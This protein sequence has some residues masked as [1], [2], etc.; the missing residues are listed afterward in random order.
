VVAI[1]AVGELHSLQITTWLNSGNAKP[2][3]VYYIP[4]RWLPG[5]ERSLLMRT[6]GQSISIC[7]HR[8]EGVPDPRSED[9]RAHTGTT[10]RLWRHSGTL[11]QPTHI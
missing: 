9:T 10:R 1:A 6:F 7:S 2:V 5:A 3:R 8:A 11:E 4:S